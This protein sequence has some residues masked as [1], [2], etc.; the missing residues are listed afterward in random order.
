MYFPGQFSRDHY[1]SSLYTA[2]RRAFIN[3]IVVT[4]KNIEDNVIKTLKELK[5]FLQDPVR[6]NL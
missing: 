4:I 6:Q 5:K 2:N 3:D 1:Y